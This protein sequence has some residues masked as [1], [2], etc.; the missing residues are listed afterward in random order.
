MLGFLCWPDTIFAQLKIIHAYHMKSRL[1]P[2]IDTQS[3]VIKFSYCLINDYV[4]TFRLISLE[5]FNRIIQIDHVAFELGCERTKPIQRS[6]YIAVANQ[7]FTIMIW[8]MSGS[9][10]ASPAVTNIFGG[11]VILI[12]FSLHVPE[13][14]SVDLSI[15]S[16]RMCY[17]N[18]STKN[19]EHHA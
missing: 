8:L 13:N 6:R 1:K 3:H 17:Q 11:S 14:Y 5:L 4:G 19:Q 2:N 10:R 18:F 16:V 15:N 7:A 9:V 12:D